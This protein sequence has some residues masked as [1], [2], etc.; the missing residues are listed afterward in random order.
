MND[1]WNEQ[2]R[3]GLG[4]QVI[5]WLLILGLLTW[6]FTGLIERQHNPNQQVATT[7]TDG[8]VREV[9]LTR[10][11][12]GHYVTSGSINGQ[13]V[14]FLLDTGATGVAIPAHLADALG[15][16][17]GRPFVTRTANGNATSYATRLDSVSVGDIQLRDVE[18]GVASGLRTREVLLGMS[19]L[20]HIEFTQRGDTLTL[21]Q[22]PGD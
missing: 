21:R 13:P 19:F 2:R 5:A 10:N 12:Q 3:L 17:R 15:V 14:T 7:V 18:A 22:Y 1:P 4:M 6:Y 20:R 16:P 9:Q 8:G 11:R